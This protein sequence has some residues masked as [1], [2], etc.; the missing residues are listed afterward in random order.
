MHPPS[1]NV[2]NILE[3]RHSTEN[4]T[5]PHIHAPFWRR[6]FGIPRNDK[7]WQP[8]N[9]AE[10]TRLRLNFETSVN[11]RPFRKRPDEKRNTA[12]P[13]SVFGITYIERK[14]E[15]GVRFLRV[16]V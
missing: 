1:W 10:I 9:I 5:Y 15:I 7:P 3:A 14:V 4:L 16:L 8:P 6:R 11:I 13:E 12:V 2:R